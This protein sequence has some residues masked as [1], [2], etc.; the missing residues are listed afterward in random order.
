VVLL[1]TRNIFAI[2]NFR[3]P[4][5]RSNG[6]SIAPPRRVE[7]STASCPRATF[8]SSPPIS[9]ALAFGDSCPSL[10]SSLWTDVGAWLVPQLAPKFSFFSFR[11]WTTYS[12]EGVSMSRPLPTSP[13]PRALTPASVSEPVHPQHLPP[14]PH[15]QKR[16]L[17]LCSCRMFSTKTHSESVASVDLSLPPPD[18]C[19]ARPFVCSISPSYFREGHSD[20]CSPFLLLFTLSSPS[21]F[22]S[23]LR[24]PFGVARLSSCCWRAVL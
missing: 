11:N 6:A 15:F 1:F 16:L 9:A 18:P 19:N 7:F 22:D 14:N 5:F 8:F 20:A 12:H 17:L 21:A 3:S 4:P 23:R 13:L 10:F 24:G 2:Y